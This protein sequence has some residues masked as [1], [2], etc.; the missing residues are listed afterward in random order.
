MWA[1]YAGKLQAQSWR[2]DGKLRI[3]ELSQNETLMFT[4]R[5]SGEFEIWAWPHKAK[6]NWLEADNAD[7]A[8]VAAFNRSMK[9]DKHGGRKHEPYVPAESPTKPT[10]P[11]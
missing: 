5:K 2:A 9:H 10:N 8:F 3:L 7:A 11:E 4:G 6:T 1:A